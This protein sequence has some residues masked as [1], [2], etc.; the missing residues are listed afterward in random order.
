VDHDVRPKGECICC[1]S[2][3]PQ[4]SVHFLNLV[5]FSCIE[6]TEVRSTCILL[7]YSPRLQSVENVLAVQK[8]H[9]VP[10]VMKL[11]AK[12][13]CKKKF[14]NVIFAPK[15]L[16]SSLVGTVIKQHVFNGHKYTLNS[17]KASIKFMQ[18]EFSRQFPKYIS[19][20]WSTFQST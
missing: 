15:S 16:I 20:E 14:I 17:A 19:M 8:A 5:G 12:K 9:S 18:F 6:S 7:K 2:V 13:T 11:L 1:F 4:K 10:N 3:S